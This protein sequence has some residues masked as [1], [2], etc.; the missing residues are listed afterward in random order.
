MIEA[1]Y[2]SHTRELRSQGRI[3]LVEADAVYRAHLAGDYERARA[4]YRSI[5]RNL[6]RSPAV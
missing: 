6:A 4:E 3:T 5:I 1:N 2:L